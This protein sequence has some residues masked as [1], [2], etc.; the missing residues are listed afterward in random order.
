MQRAKTKK[1]TL[2]AWSKDEVKLLK[3]LYPDGRAEEIAERTGRP[4]TS[5][6]RR[7]YY[8]GIQ[9]REYLLHKKSSFPKLPAKVSQLTCLPDKVLWR[10]KFRSDLD[11]LHQIGYM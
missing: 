6:R 5:V 10:D 1:K 8:M 2:I 11:K 9:A 4:L 7:A 3:E